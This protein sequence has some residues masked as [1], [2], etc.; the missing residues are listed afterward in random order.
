MTKI[1]SKFSLAFVAAVALVSASISN[2]YAAFENTALVYYTTSHNYEGAD[3]EMVGLTERVAKEIAKQTDAKLFELKTAKKYPA[4]YNETADQTRKELDDLAKVEFAENVDISSYDNVIIGFPIYWGTFPRVFASWFET[5]DFTD[6]HVYVS[7][8]SQGSRFGKS[9]QD[10]KEAAKGA[11]GVHQLV[12]FKSAE[13]VGLSDD[14][15]AKAIRDAIAKA[16]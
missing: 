2:A 6:K 3:P 1:F 8:T 7:V 11:H 5:Q 10:V 9:I 15:L 4:T 13:L 14:D 12:D 16:K